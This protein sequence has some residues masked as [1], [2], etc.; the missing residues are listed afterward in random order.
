MPP[1][2][3]RGSALG[4]QRAQLPDIVGFLPCVKVSVC[5][6]PTRMTAVICPVEAR[7]N[8]PARHH[9]QR[10]LTENET[11]WNPSSRGSQT[12]GGNKR[13]LIVRFLQEQETT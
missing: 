12:S 2:R 9:T 3:G 13:L 5:S 8:E 1:R 10:Q 7:I 11:D 4:S 6:V